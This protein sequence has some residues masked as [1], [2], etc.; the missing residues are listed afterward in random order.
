MIDFT[1]LVHPENKV[2][3]FLMSLFFVLFCISVMTLI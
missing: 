1:V 3:R 2:N